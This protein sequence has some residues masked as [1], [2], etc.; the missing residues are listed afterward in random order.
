[1]NKFKFGDKVWHEQY[2]LGVISS[3]Q[4]GENV[5]VAFED[6]TA[7]EYSH[8]EI[9]QGLLSKFVNLSG[10]IKCNK[11]LPPLEEK[12]LLLLGGEQ[13]IAIFAGAN[14]HDMYWF[15]VLSADRETNYQDLLVSSKEDAHWMSLPT[16]PQD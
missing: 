16:P 12:I 5:W 9:N 7:Y 1:M 2:G 8:E 6:G 3:M 4:R 10:W 11:L 15:H 13:Y 14:S